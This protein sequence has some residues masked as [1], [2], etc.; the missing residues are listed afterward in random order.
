MLDRGQ[1]QLHAGPMGGNETNN[2]SS[3]G[4]L[5]RKEREEFKISK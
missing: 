5:N 2:L 4:S 1:I 3:D